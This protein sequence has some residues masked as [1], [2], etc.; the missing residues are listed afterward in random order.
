MKLTQRQLEAMVRLRTNPDFTVYQ[1]VVREH[2]SHLLSHLT[3][4]TEPPMV[5]RAQG[6]IQAL[7]KVL[8]AYDE[9]PDTI[10]KLS[11]R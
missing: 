7:E 6:G 5:Y 4:A 1:E 9:A 2:Q 8:E 10:R 3:Q 11:G